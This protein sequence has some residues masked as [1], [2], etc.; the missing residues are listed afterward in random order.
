[1]W[2]MTKGAT[3]GESG[4]GGA[5]TKA[6]AGTDGATTKAGAGTDAATEAD[7]DGCTT[8]EAGAA[9][10]KRRRRRARRCAKSFGVSS[11]VGVEPSGAGDELLEGENVA[12]GGRESARSGGMRKRVIELKIFTRSHAIQ[13]ARA[14]GG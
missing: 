2:E 8:T 4:G 11:G 14:L 5:T 3:A 13:L 6:G 9:G 10:A 1:M 12:M 7:V